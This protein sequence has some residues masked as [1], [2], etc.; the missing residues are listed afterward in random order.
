[1]LRN[2]LLAGW[3]ALAS[4]CLEIPKWRGPPVDAGNVL[5]AE[6]TKDSTIADAEVYSDTRRERRDA[7]HTQDVYDT[8]PQA[9]V[10]GGLDAVVLRDAQNLDAMVPV[11]VQQEDAGQR[12]VDSGRP[13]VGNPPNPCYINRFDE[14]NDLASILF[15]GGEW[16]RHP[17]GYL[18]QTESNPDATWSFAYVRELTV[19][20]FEAK[21]RIRTLEDNNPR[22]GVGNKHTGLVFRYDA[23]TSAG[24]MLQM[25]GLDR[26]FFSITLTDL[27]T[28]ETIQTVRQDCGEIGCQINVWE[29]LKLRAEG[30]QITVYLQ[31]RELFSVQNNLYSTGSIGLAAYSFNAS[32]FDDLEICPIR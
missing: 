22:M 14:Q 26:N 25:E 23:E 24:Y 17:E 21:V 13:D 27:L 2:A 8:I 3:L 1:M 32:H 7:D 20:D 10:Q 15:Q 11:D 6:M 19:S 9:D 29:E 31:E 30:D 12:I 5:D 28:R 16:S 4:G 18:Q